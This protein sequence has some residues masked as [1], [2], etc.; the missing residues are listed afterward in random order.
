MANIEEAFSNKINN[1]F[2]VNNQDGIDYFFTQR[3]ISEFEEYVDT[4]TMERK[5]K[6]KDISFNFIA[7]T[8]PYF[9]YITKNMNGDDISVK[10]ELTVYGNVN[11]KYHGIIESKEGLFPCI[12]LKLG[13]DSQLFVNVKL[14]NGEKDDNENE[15]LKEYIS[16]IPISKRY[17]IEPTISDNKSEN[18][19]KV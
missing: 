1:V 17:Q 19:L 8:I 12:L 14:K 3:K 9:D 18:E 10:A 2:N 5:K 11:L 6:K 7:I 15:I 16:F 13:E 4:K